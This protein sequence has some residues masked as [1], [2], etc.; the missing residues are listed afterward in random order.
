MFL[1]MRSITKSMMAG[2][3]LTTL[4]LSSAWALDEE[5]Q[6]AKE[7]GVRLYSAHQYEASI[8]YLEA[9][10]EAGDVDSMYYLG[11]ATRGETSLDWY[12]RAAQHGDPYAMLRLRSSGACER[13]DICPANG[14]DW[15]EAAL[16][17]ALPMAE[18]GDAD[19]MFALYPV[20]ATLGYPSAPL[21]WLKQAAEEG[22]VE[23]Q[24][25]LGQRIQDDRTAY[26]DETERLEAAE[27]WFRR[28]AEAGYPRAMSALARL[29]NEQG[30]YDESW[31]W[32][33]KAS[34]GG[35]INARQWLAYCYIE[36][37]EENNGMCQ[38]EKEPG[39][40]WA[41][42]LAV[43]EEAPNMHVESAL[44]YYGD[45][46][47]VTVEHREEGEH[48]MEEWLNRE[49]PL[50]YFPMKFFGPHGR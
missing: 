19:A 35:H 47:D 30:H 15:G 43:N 21:K 5:A 10:A 8:P 9:A 3:T 46:D 39:K 22:N 6:T 40:G 32:M 34:E 25:R 24:H 14:E 33:L 23:A 41:I 42:L 13:K 38:V 31:E 4:M 37:D 44:R 49:P 28:A 27:P 7:A 12:H 11:E 50:S 48:M 17:S 36:P 26:S 18:S 2:L 16:H 20:Y 1:P 29:L 45:S